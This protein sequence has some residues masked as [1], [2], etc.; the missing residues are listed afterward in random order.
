MSEKQKRPRRSIKPR[1]GWSNIFEAQDCGEALFG[2][3]LLY[4]ASY[5][6]RPTL[7]MVYNPADFE[8]TGKA[9][10]TVR[11]VLCGM[12]SRGLGSHEDYPMIGHVEV[13]AIR[14]TLHM[15]TGRILHHLATAHGENLGGVDD[16]G[17]F[18]SI[19]DC[20]HL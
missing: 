3:G 7:R 4:E 2:Q 9:V 1:D 15:D 18:N 5:Q 11:C 8:L 20:C 10:I 13:G 19:L 14:L 16:E 12:S 6:N 17:F